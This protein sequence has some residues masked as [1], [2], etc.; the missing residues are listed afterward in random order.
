MRV[1]L[2]PD[3][4][5]GSLSASEVCIHLARGLTAV[6]PSV[7]LTTIAVADGGEGTLEAAFGAGF[8]AVPARAGGPTGEPVNTRYARRGDVAI[9][10]LAA[11]CGLALLPGGRPAPLTASSRGAGELV[12][13]ALDAGCRT[14][15]LGLGGSASTD[16]GAG[17]LRALG[18]E[19]RRADGTP[20]ADGGAALAEAAGLDLTGLHPALARARL[21]VAADVDS[22]LCGPGG[23]AALYAPQKGASAA[24]VAGLDV[25][26]T[27]WAD[28]VEAQL[29]TSAAGDR[30]RVAPGAGAA[31]GVGFAALAVLGAS[32]RPGIDV[33]LELVGL[34]SRL[35]GARLV[36]TGE[37]AMDRQSLHGKA[38]VGV[39]AAARRAGVP[40]VAVCGRLAVS[41]AD[42]RAAGIDAVYPLADFEPDLARGLARAGAL[43]EEAARRVAAEWLLDTPRPQGSVPATGPAEDEGRGGDR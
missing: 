13:A 43:V 42:L 3:K 41:A 25:A 23:A 20:V 40:T 24:D 29:G 36:I 21:L 2:A 19:V 4:F 1:V 27:R 38:A 28:L 8:A 16:G 22:P 15:V 14:V 33:V 31:G 39:A 7:E 12:A 32:I 10:E 6:A 17:L 18:A 5:R 9:V 11:A 35:T 37:G 30:S 34:A 26:L